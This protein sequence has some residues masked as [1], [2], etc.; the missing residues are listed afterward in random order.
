MR[1]RVAAD[2]TSRITTSTMRILG[3]RSVPKVHGRA[4]RLHLQA[5]WG[6]GDPLVP[7]SQGCF[8]HLRYLLVSEAKRQSPT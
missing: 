6:C 4:L 8:L 2:S 7:S 3:R 1:E 5:W